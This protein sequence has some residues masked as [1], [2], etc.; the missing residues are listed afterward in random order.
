MSTMLEDHGDHW[1]VKTIYAEGKRRRF[2]RT[3]VVV[4]KGD[5]AALREEITRQA[6][7]ARKMAGVDQSPQVPV[8]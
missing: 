5:P 3:A 7:E 1:V 4:P 6:E 2:G 8:V